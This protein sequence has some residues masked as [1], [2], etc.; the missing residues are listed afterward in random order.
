MG[1]LGKLSCE[2]E[3]GALLSGAACGWGLNV[4]IA[5]GG[6]RS[7]GVAVHCLMGAV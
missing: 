6:D 4:F 2:I 3:A 1:F 7:K 5:W